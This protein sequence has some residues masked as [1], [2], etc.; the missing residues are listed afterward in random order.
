MITTS[1]DFFRE[2]C[3]SHFIVRVRKGYSMF[4]GERELETPLLWPSALC[5]SRSPGLLNRMPRGPALCWLSLLQLISN[6]SG[7]QLFWLPTQSG[8]PRAPLAW[9]GFPYHISSITPTVLLFVLT[10]LYNSSR[11]LNRPLNPWNGMF[12]RHQAEITV[13]QFTGHSLPVHQSMSVQLL[14]FFVLSHFIRQIP[15]TRFLSI[16][17]HW[18]VSIPSGASLWND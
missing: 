4:Y 15:P 9:C 11:P 14:F 17:G 12:D 7:P 5:L 10:E 3:T 8:A 1:E 6:F 2:I 13:I 16:T 18:D